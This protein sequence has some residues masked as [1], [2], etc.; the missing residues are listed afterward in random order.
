MAGTPK[1]A[2]VKK[3]SAPKAKKP[4]TAYQKYMQKALKVR[5][6]V[7]AVSAVLFIG[8]GGGGGGCHVVVQV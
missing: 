3:T 1:K 7:C 6:C 4:P 5:A 8:G 2:S